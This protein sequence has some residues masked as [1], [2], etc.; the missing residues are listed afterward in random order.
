MIS[1]TD[2][3]EMAAR[4]ILIILIGHNIG[5]PKPTEKAMK[6][7]MNSLTEQLLEGPYMLDIPDEQLGHTWEVVWDNFTKLTVMLGIQSESLRLRVI[8]RQILPGGLE[9]FM[10]VL[11][12]NNFD[13]LSEWIAPDPSSQSVFQMTV[14]LLHSIVK[15]RLE[16]RRVYTQD[17]Q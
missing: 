7:N 6:K 11:E 15:L 16:I 5:L 1:I 9:K 10:E 8:S 13:S 4:N 12:S 17:N 3:I 14:K 2:Q